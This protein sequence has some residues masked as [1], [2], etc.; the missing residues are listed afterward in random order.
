M[1]EKSF[2]ERDFTEKAANWGECVFYQEMYEIRDTWNLMQCYHHII[3][4]PDNCDD[5][6]LNVECTPEDMPAYPG[7]TEEAKDYYNGDP[8]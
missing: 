8:T 3:N 7:A 2:F 4:R 6:P 1:K 5:C